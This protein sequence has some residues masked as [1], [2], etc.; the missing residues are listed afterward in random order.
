MKLHVEVTEANLREI[1]EH[2]HVRYWTRVA[3]L[4]QASRGSGLSGLLSY[5]DDVG[6]LT[7]ALREAFEAYG[8]HIIPSEQI[9]GPYAPSS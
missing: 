8:H 7:A 9:H 1:A 3:D 5:R 4:S 6:C 2:A